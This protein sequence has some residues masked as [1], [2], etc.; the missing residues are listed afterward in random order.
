M[1][2]SFP[3]LPKMNWCLEFGAG[4]HPG[5]NLMVLV[6]MTLYNSSFAQEGEGTD[7]GSILHLIHLSIC[8]LKK[9]VEKRL[10]AGKVKFRVE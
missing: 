7:H 6:S 10:S 8:Y 9:A 3:L 5:V 2:I 1:Q 4:Y